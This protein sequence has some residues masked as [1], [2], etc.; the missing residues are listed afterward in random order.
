MSENSDKEGELDYQGLAPV[1]SI[2]FPELCT[3]SDGKPCHILDQL[4]ACNKVLSVI[5]CRLDERPPDKLWLVSHQKMIETSATED[6]RRKACGL[7]FRILKSHCCLG[8]IELFMCAHSQQLE[9]HQRLIVR[10]LQSAPALRR[11]NITVLFSSLSKMPELPCFSFLTLLETLECSLIDCSDVAAMLGP[12][13]RTTF[14]LTILR[15]DISNN[16]VSCEREL[17][18]ALATCKLL[19]S[20]TVR[21]HVANT[22]TKD[23]WMPFCE[24]LEKTSSLRSV[25]IDVGSFL[26]AQWL[27]STLEALYGN[28][29]LLNVGLAN[30]VVDIEE[31][32]AIEKFITENSGIR[33][34]ELRWC[35]WRNDGAS[36]ARYDTDDF[37][38]LTPRI[39][40]WLS[41]LKRNHVLQKL[42]LNFRGFSPAECEAFLEELAINRNLRTVFIEDFQEYCWCLRH[43]GHRT[44]DG[45]KCGALH[46]RRAE[47]KIVEC[48]QIRQVSLN[49]A[50][51]K[52]LAWFVAEA[53]PLQLG[54]RVAGLT[55]YL[56]HL[57][58]SHESGSTIA[59]FIESSHSLE[60]LV[61][62]F[63]YS[64]PMSE[65]RRAILSAVHRNASIQLFHLVYPS[66]SSLEAEQLAR[67]IRQS[68]TMCWFTLDLNY[69]AE[70]MFLSQIFPDISR[71]YILVGA[72]VEGVPDVG[73]GEYQNLLSVMARNERLVARAAEFVAGRS[74]K[75]Y[76]EALE[77]VSS[78]P[79]LVNKLCALASVDEAEASGMIN[80]S[81]RRLQDMDDFMRIAG[82]VKRR[83][84][85]LM[86]GWGKLQLDDVD[87]YSWHCVRKY[88]RL[89][90]VQN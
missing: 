29:G 70:Q 87:E 54:R 69:E 55:L 81:V 52:A 10:S 40:P 18:A 62:D 88:L 3:A 2:T 68:K 50:T 77:F 16:T 33:K 7:I 82:V 89:A 23:D 67:T 9:E 11:L 59:E 32:I 47:I 53:L 90:D 63:S 6:A 42:R 5:Q 15:L 64:S 84:V 31:T 27:K 35:S 44:K 12:L 76:A 71:N 45:G 25:Y 60:R 65:V 58:L 49:I 43:R 36:D 79:A 57:N 61:L 86:K 38:T 4:P 74:S 13:L 37:G 17:W 85:C 26:P 56:A 66:C 24:Y 73:A 48:E 22:P 1:A 20:L 34:F 28:K 75:H 30:F 39:L 14:S 46:D 8:T 21:F 51:P 19:S 72:Y 41:I 78:S 83:V 80:E